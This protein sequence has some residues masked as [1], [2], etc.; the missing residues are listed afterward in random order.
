M[1]AKH[2]LLLLLLMLM[3]FATIKPCYGQDTMYTVRGKMILGKII[4]QNFN[5]V[6]YYASDDSTRG[7]HTIL[8][9][10]LHSINFHNGDSSLYRRYKPNAF[11]GDLHQNIP[12]LNTWNIDLAGFGFFSISQSYERRTKD[13]HFGFRVPLYIGFFDAAFAGADAF[14]PT[15]GPFYPGDYYFNNPPESFS[16]STGLNFKYYPVENRIIR[17]FIGPEVTIGSLTVQKGWPSFDY[18]FY[19]TRK[20]VTDGTFASLAKTGISINAT[21]KFNITID[22]SAGIGN[23]FGRAQNSIAWT[24]LW[25]IGFTMGINF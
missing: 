2:P 11:R 18:N 13:G 23:A 1:K 4:R 8:K 17:L 15:I 7:I 3:A 21:D 19:Y 5:V 25:Q 22:G 10:A 14:I 12:Q 9:F 20:F 6:K 16:L 24:G